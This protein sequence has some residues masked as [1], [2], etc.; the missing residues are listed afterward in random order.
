ME[1]H[2]PTPTAGRGAVGEV[3]HPSVL[4][5]LKLQARADL[6]WLQEGMEALRLADHVG[7]EAKV[8]MDLLP[9]LRQ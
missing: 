8:V 5:L 1:G 6:L 7:A 2:F 4:D 9:P 3:L